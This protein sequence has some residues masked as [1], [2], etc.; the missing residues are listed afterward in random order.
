MSCGAVEDSIAVNREQRVLG[1]L[2]FASGWVWDPGIENAN[3]RFYGQ[4]LV[5]NGESD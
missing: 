2:C 5:K 3:F 1:V 4:R